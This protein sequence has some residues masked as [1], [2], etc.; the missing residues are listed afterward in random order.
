MPLKLSKTEALILAR[1]LE[2]VKYDYCNL[3][4]GGKVAQL[5][6][7]RK[8]NDLQERLEKHSDDQRMNGRRMLWGFGDRLR[9]WVFGTPREDKL[10][11]DPEP[12][13]GVTVQSNLFE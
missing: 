10:P 1:A 12:E 5:Q 11:K 2:R 3:A 4:G 9:W 13:K 8:I 6:F 7:M